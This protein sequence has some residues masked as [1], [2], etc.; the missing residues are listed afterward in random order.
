[1]FKTINIA[2]IIIIIRN[3]KLLFSN[4]ILKTILFTEY[5]STSVK[6]I[7]VNVNVTTYV[8]ILL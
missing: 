3:N 8:F 1:M 6:N 2:I 5:I 4:L 7:Y